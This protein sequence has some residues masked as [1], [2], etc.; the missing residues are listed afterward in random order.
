MK[1]LLDIGNTRIKWAFVSG[2]GLSDAGE[3]VHRE[4]A[5]ALAGFTAALAHR[6]DDVTAINVAG[7][8]TGA[9]VADALRAHCGAETRFISVGQ[10]CGE[11]RNGYTEWQQLGVDRWAAVV[12]AWYQR[13]SDVLVVDAGTA[14]T[15]DLVR[16]DGT[17]EGGVILPGLRMAEEALG[18]ATADIAAFAAAAPGP[19]ES[20]WYGRATAEAVQRGAH[21]S[22]CAAIDRAVNEFPS[23]AM[24]PVLLT[25]GDAAKLQPGLQ[26][27]SEIRPLLVL[28]GLRHLDSGANDAEAAGA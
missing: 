14:V 26:S 15:I 20:G 1:L 18:V 3:V 6:P 27:R 10:S 24:P 5:D 21:F 22:L 23:G 2:D 4:R 17:H 12:G 8:A 13:R 25:G 7:A 16:A 11:V 19:G 28:E 9:A